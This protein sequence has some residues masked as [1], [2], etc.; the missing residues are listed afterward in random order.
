MLDVAVVGAGAAGLAAA[1]FTARRAPGLAIAVLDGAKKPGAKILASGGGRCNVT[2]RVVTERDFHGSDPRRIRAVLA[3]FSAGRAADFFRELGVTL[4]EEEGG[5]LFPDTN[6]ARTVLDALLAE[7]A[8][9]R[10][11]ILAGHHVTALA[12]AGGAGDGFLLAT[13]CGPVRARFVVLATGGKSFPKTGSDGAGYSLAA[14]LGHSVVEPVPALSPL[15]LSGDFHAPLAGISLPVELTLAGAGEKPARIR[16]TLLWTHFGAS[17]PAALDVSRHWNRAR[18]EGKTPALRANFFP[19]TDAAGLDQG[20]VAGA[21]SIGKK[22]LKGVLSGT[23]PARFAEAALARLGLSANLHWSHL[24]REDR[25]R[26]AEALTG[27]ELPV[28][29]CRGFPHAEV[30]AGGVPLSEVDTATMESHKCPGLFLVGEILD[31]D[32]RLGGFNFQ[33]SWSS[34]F[35]AGMGLARAAAGVPVFTPSSGENP[36]GGSPDR[37]TRRKGNR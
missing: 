25:R 16:G 34:G 10:V 11:E 23:L 20:W 17:G 22:T 8:S 36:A 4:H 12:R 21:A 32:G 28:A 30:T 19:G 37:S 13:S 1:V 14:G 6:R 24:A 33:W 31:V 3:A 27:W 26:L 2:N 5:K 7:A 29:G 15:V 9:R 35:V 18:S